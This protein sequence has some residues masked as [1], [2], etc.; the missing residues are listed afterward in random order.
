[1]TPARHKLHAHARRRSRARTAA[2]LRR[3]AWV[4]LLLAAGCGR[5][6]LPLDQV[7][8]DAVPLDP[9]FAL[10][11]DIFDRQCI[12]CHSGSGPGDA[13]PA[14]DGATGAA[15]TALGGSEPGLSTCADIIANLGDIE[16]DVFRD[17]SMPP[18]AWPRLTSEEKLILFRWISNGAKAPCN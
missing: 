7:D 3:L 9:D 17:N 11:Y 18:G 16:R 14:R 10:V 15:A 6:D 4:A 1:M 12:P 2:M 13:P 5:G 8:P